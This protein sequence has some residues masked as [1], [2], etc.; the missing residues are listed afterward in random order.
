LRQAWANSS[1]TSIF[2]VTKEKWTG[3]VAAAIG[4]LLCK[5]KALS[6]NSSPTKKVREKER[7]REREGSELLVSFW[8]FKSC[9]CT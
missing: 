5:C 8:S 9:K 3:G 2:K 1:R 4:C 7:E 6:S